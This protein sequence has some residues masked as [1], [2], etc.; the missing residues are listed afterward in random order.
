[1]KYFLVVR[2]EKKETQ[3]VL[4]FKSFDEAREQE[5][6]LDKAGHKGEL[7]IG[8]GESKESFLKTFSEYKD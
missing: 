8:Q 7:V 3:Q 4:E 5:R 2:S 1:M 6:T